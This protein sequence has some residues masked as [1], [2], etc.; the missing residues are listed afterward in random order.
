MGGEGDISKV[1]DIVK[2]IEQNFGSIETWKADFKACAVA[3]KLSG[4]GLLVY[5]KLYSGRLLNVLVDEH[6]YG[7][8]L[9]RH[10]INSM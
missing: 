1:P 2:A 10:S 3:A 6:Q 9:G 7:A 8:H 4:W 5:D